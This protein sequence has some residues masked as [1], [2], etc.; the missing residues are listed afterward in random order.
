MTSTLVNEGGAKERTHSRE[1]GCTKF[2]PEVVLVSNGKV[3]MYKL[4]PALDTS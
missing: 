3:L 1:K 4:D 2:C